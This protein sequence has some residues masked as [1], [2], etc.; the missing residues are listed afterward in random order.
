MGKII[1]LEFDVVPLDRDP[2]LPAHA[3][4]VID[5]G[6][7]GTATI[8]HDYINP[9]CPGIQRVLDRLLAALAG[10]QPPPAAIRLTNPSGSRL[11]RPT[12]SVILKQFCSPSHLRQITPGQNFTILH[13]WLTKASTP[14]KSATMVSSHQSAD[15]F[16]IDGIRFD[17]PGA[18]CWQPVL[19][20]PA[21]QHP[22]DRPCY[23][24]QD[25]KALTHQRRCICPYTVASANNRTLHQRHQFV[26]RS[27]KE[28]LQAAMLIDGTKR[29]NR[30]R[31]FTML[32]KALCPKLGEPVAHPVQS[33]TIRHK[34]GLGDAALLPETD[35]PSR[36]PLERFI[37]TTA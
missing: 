14:I 22:S 28:K 13:G 7:G 21:V 1:A 24:R 19:P 6:D 35:R 3:H 36:R 20:S 8:A 18:A 16:L 12:F 26:A 5:H 9:G 27:I 11:I 29:S 4:A 25:R 30:R 37:N 31:A 10:V 33:I 17:N 23:A 15:A 32:A 2:L 34:N